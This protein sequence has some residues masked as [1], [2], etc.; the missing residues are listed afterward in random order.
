MHKSDELLKIFFLGVLA[1]FLVVSVNCAK[2]PTKTND[3]TDSAFLEESDEILPNPFKGFVPWIG[4]QN[5]SYPTQLQ[6]ANFIWKDLEPKPGVYNWGKLEQNWGNISTTGRR[7]GFRISAALPGVRGHSDIPQWL[8]DQ[9][10]RMRAYTID[11]QYGLAPDWDDPQFLQ[12]HHQFILALGARYDQDARVAWIDIGSYGFWGEWHVY[13]NDSLAASQTSKQA[14]LEDYFAAFPTKPKVI[15]FD[16]D[17][18]TAIVIAHGG[19]IR[20][21]CLGTAAANDWYLSSLN[22]ID[23]TLNER[24]WKTAIITGEFCGGEAGAQ[25]GTTTRFNLN[26]Q[27]IQRTHWS[28]IGPA[29]GNLSSINEEHK[30]NLDLLY[31]KLGYR[32]VLRKVTLPDQTKKGESATVTIE[33]ENKGVAPFYFAWPLVAYLMTSDG[34]VVATQ[35]LDIDIRQWLPGMATSTATFIIPASVASGDYELRLAIHDPLTA[36]PAVYF[37]N[38]NRDA[39]LRF[40]AGKV[41]VN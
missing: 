30:N 25:Q 14:I 8:V 34:N 11:G 32:L 12:A 35:N 26:Y 18:A 31:K 17:F 19:G 16:D 6:Y 9:G 38:K 40:L 1:Y 37:A 39:Q 24:A 5:P 27:F 2:Q 20:N 36:K 28:F 29:G 3:Q 22:Q 7:V 33:V 13:L 41:V 15:A 21:D 23:P 10:I 4:D